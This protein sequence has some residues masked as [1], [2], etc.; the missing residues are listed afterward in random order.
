MKKKT[1]WKDIGLSIRQSKG[2]FF[3]I[4]SLMMIGA[5]ALVGLKVTTPNME[6][7]AQAYV[8][9][10]QML[11]LA[12]MGDYGL[13]DADVQ[14]LDS[15]ENSRV[16][17]AYLTDAS[18]SG[19]QDAIR[20]FSQTEN[21]SKFQLLSGKMPESD[22]D[23][24]LSDQL[25]NDYKIGDQITFKLGEDSPLKQDRYKV[26]GFVHSAEI[27]DKTSMGQSSV[28]TGEL[29]GYAVV[30]PKAFDSAV[31]MI[32][33]IQFDDTAKL[34]YQ[35]KAYQDTVAKHQ[36]D[37]ERMLADNGP[38]RLSRLKESAQK[39]ITD[40]QEKIS[41]SEKE[42]SDA[43][44]KIKNGESQLADG[45]NQLDAA[46]Q[47]LASG[48]EKLT[49]TGQ[50]LA[51][52][53]AK[54]DATGQELSPA[55]TKL[56][57]G[58]AELDARKAQLD[59][60][61][62]QLA[63]AKENL[64][65]TAQELNQTAAQIQEGQFQWNQAKLALEEQ[66]KQVQAAG[67]DP[68]SIPEIQAIQ[69]QLQEQEHQL[70]AGLQAYEEGYGHL[71]AGYS[72]YQ[73]QEKQYLEG[74]NA[75]DTGLASYQE[76]LAQ[77]QSGYAQYQAGLAQYQSGLAQYQVGQAE[78]ET[79][80]ASIQ[81]EQDKLNQAKDQ[82]AS[83]KQTFQRESSDA[84]KKI[85]DAKSELTEAQDK[86]K[87]LEKPVYHVYTRSTI[88]GSAGYET[89]QNA[90]TSISAV[91]NIFPVVLYLVA[92]MVTLTTMTR[93]VDEERNNAGILR[94]LGYTNGQVM[95]KFLIYGLVASLAGTLVGILAGNLILSPMIANI[96]TKSTIVGQARMDFYPSWTLLTIAL[97]LLS[98]VLP[99]YLVVRK[100]LT[101]EP[102]QLLQGK[103][104]VSGSSILLE[105]IPFIWKRL[106]FT[107]KVTA[108]NIFRYKQRM[109]M[110]IFGVAGSVALLFAGLGIQSSISGVA[111][112]QFGQLISYD[113][114]VVEKD[115]VKQAQLEEINQLVSS[116][117]VKQSSLIEIKSLT[118]SVPGLEK[119]QQVNLLISKKDE[120][121]DF[122]QFRTRSK[123]AISLT[124][125]GAILTEK[126]ANL[127]QVQVGDS[128]TIHMDDKTVNIRV[129]AI[130]EMYA[131]HFIYMTSHYFQKVSNQDF[132]A[133]AYL[134]TLK[135]RSQNQVQDMAARFLA[136][137][138]VAAV[139]QNTALI[140]L[141]N[142]IAQSLQS[143]MLI[144]IVLSILLAVVILYNLT[145]INVAE[146]IRELSTIKVLGFHN[147]EVTMYIYRETIVLSLIGILSGLG[148]GIFLHKLILSLIGSSA[149]MFNPSVALYVY[150]TP[151]ISIIGILAILGVMVNHRLRKVDMLEALK[152]GE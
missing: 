131:G 31:Y 76:S 43:E 101:E 44:K 78:L 116:Q 5:I 115:F 89:Y 65:K 124:D 143:V 46:K 114:I 27:W 3:S 61:A 41:T 50:E 70:N 102:A 92:A 7:T 56:E 22:K 9:K 69:A 121:A 120:L 94:S 29:M 64:D 14:E 34:A 134:L 144:L 150:I 135:N 13:D 93:F 54:L 81:Q 122:I 79:S 96:I 106:S 77:Y 73:E 138:G 63:A 152:S 32:A 21:I 140:T 12:V 40:G 39:E 132:Q 113:M 103:P 15:L 71:R 24:A 25:K 2:R 149:I 72:Q 139:S 80:A 91:G 95:A 146:R 10:S 19:K 26:T 82:L 137:E 119:E 85:K 20:I 110:T 17:F 45:Q 148:L 66:I 23:I 87:E 57:A 55:W 88:P 67:Q 107:H 99:T 111:E 49:S 68:A 97:A 136:L 104:P 48:K 130:T 74:K 112:T 28:G 125:Q 151:V 8:N 52:A 118:E 100:E 128:L 109:F 75:Y 59:Q 42:L 62:I 123:E 36:K 145:N 35:S 53:K 1:Y 33:R 4:F 18:I 108:R 141:I 38:Q 86:V 133:N 11:D 117:Q 84:Q 98:A 83:S 127:Y 6:R 60:A 47:E 126:L 58:K 37:V 142:T 105:K 129:A 51:N 16:E 90:T 147:R 30:S